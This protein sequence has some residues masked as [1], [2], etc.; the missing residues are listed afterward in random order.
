MPGAT[1]P[2]RSSRSSARAAA[3]RGEVER[4]PTATAACRTAARPRR[5]PAS[6]AAS[7]SWCRRPGRW[8]G[9]RAPAARA[10]PAAPSLKRP[11][12]RKLFDVG[13]CAIAV[14]V[15]CRNAKVV[16]AE[17]HAVAVDRARAGEAVARVDV[18]V[19]R[20]VGEH[21]RAPA[22]SRRGSPTRATARST[23]GMLALERAGRVELRGRGRHREARR[24]RVGQPAVAVP[25]RDQ[26]LRLVV[27]ALRGVEQRRR[28]VAV[29][30]HL[31]GD[32]AQV[33]R[34]R[35]LEQHVGRR[36]VHGAEH[37]R[38]RD[39]V[40]QVLAQVGARHAS[41]RSPRRRSAPRPGTCSPRAS[42]AAAC[43]RRR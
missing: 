32:Q 43:R 15:S 17:V 33:E 38:R 36:R 7:R 4:A 20:R 37:G 24:D 23:S 28:R 25:A 42:R 12:P 16:L 22:R 1:L 34:A 21:R 19:R 11:L 10:S 35:L 13:Q 8:R 29:H 3:A 2:M 14:P 9:P 39:P 26:R 31:A 40:A 6:C 27:A 18:E 30:Q 41:A 5:R